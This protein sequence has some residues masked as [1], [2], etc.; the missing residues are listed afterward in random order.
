M[1][2][3]VIGLCI[4]ALLVSVGPA[5]GQAQRGTISVTVASEDG[6]RLPGATVSA[7]SDE[8]LSRRTAVT[9]AQGVATLTALDPAANYVVT[10][11]LDGFNTVRN[12]S[13]LVRA[14]QNTPL[15]VTLGLATVREELIV[16]AEA[17]ER[18][19][20]FGR[21][22]WRR[23]VRIFPLYFLYLGCLVAYDVAA[24]VSYLMRAATTLIAQVAYTRNDSNIV[25]ND[26]DRVVASVSVRMN[27]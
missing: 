2:R 14:G 20:F 16:T 8:T 15:S 21:F 12:E 9:D 6:S 4:L 22:Y 26:F 13:V 27:F 11:S 3:G 24:G 18:G 17:P 5:F 1:R 7:E 25:I 19:A 23:L 10:T